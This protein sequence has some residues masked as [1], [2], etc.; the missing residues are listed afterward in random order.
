MSNLTDALIAAKLIG[1]QGGGSGGGSGLP[2]PVQWDEVIAPT[3]YSFSEAQPGIYVCNGNVS[4]W[5]LNVGD[6]LRLTWDGAPYEIALFDLNNKIVGGNTSIVGEGIDTGEP[7]FAFFVGG[8]RFQLITKEIG[9]S[10]IISFAQ[11]E[12]LPDG[13]IMQVIDGEWTTVADSTKPLLITLNGNDEIDITYNQWRNALRS[14]SNIVIYDESNHEYYPVVAPNASE[15]PV[16]NGMRFEWDSAGGG[17][18]SVYAL[19][20]YANS[21]E[22]SDDEIITVDSVERSEQLIISTT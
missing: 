16:I 5:E 7:F 12:V 17:L 22:E 8:G 4:G 14:A 20:I 1:A 10:H 13:T 3:E 18:I 11:R 9:A 6:V 2:A 21:P 19:N 15:P